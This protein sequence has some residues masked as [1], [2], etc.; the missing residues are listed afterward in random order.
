MKGLNFLIALLCLCLS[1]CQALIRPIAGDFDL[2]V[3]KSKKELSPQ[4]KKLI[5]EA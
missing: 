1:G 4:A 5:D 2:D 3:F